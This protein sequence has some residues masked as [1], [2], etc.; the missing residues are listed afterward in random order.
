MVKGLYSLEAVLG[1]VVIFLGLSFAFSSP[2]S[3]I[4]LKQLAFDC[5][6]YL[7][8]SGSLRQSALS[9]N[10][11]GISAEISFC[12]PSTV[13]NHVRICGSSCTPALSRNGDAE[14]IE[15]FIYGDSD[16]LLPT[17]ITLSVWRK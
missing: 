5:I 6:S 3:E 2:Q 11:S 7:D 8:S 15:Y 13:E 12:L 14:N 9:M 10:V 16:V 4:D 17:E 1:V